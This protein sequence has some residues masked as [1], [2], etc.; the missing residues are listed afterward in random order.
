[1]RRKAKVIYF[2]ALLSICLRNFIVCT[3]DRTQKSRRLNP[4]SSD[5]KHSA[6]NSATPLIIQ[7]FSCSKDK[8]MS[9]IIWRL[10][11]LTSAL[12]PSMKASPIAQDIWLVDVLEGPL[13]YAVHFQGIELYPREG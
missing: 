11:G 2:N 12:G 8:I 10:R 13:I 9:R 7:I 6:N 5:Y 1:M 4:K 3:T